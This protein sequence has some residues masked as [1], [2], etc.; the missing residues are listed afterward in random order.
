M[1][2]YSDVRAY[3]L[4]AYAFIALLYILFFGWVRREYRRLK[5]GKV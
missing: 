5:K 1:I 4:A 2:L 3:E